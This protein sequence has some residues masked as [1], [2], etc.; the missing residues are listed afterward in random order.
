MK[1][2]K[3]NVRTRKY[4]PYDLPVGVIMYTRNLNAITSCAQCGYQS[5]F[6]NCFTS[7]EVHDPN[8]LGYPVCEECYRKETARRN[9]T[10]TQ[11]KPQQLNNDTI[12][13]L[14]EISGFLEGMSVEM[15]DR[16][17]KITLN[18]VEKLKSIN[19][20]QLKGTYED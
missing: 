19:K 6:G 12:Y 5:V 17:K 16:R 1:A 13:L 7:M 11:N 9:E 2:Q 3:W 14:A 8:G 18:Y 20:E 4:E 15:D 10:S